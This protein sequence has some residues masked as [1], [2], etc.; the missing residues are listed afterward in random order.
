VFK[1]SLERHYLN[2]RMIRVIKRREH[3]VWKQNSQTKDLNNIKN[4]RIIAILG[5]IAINSLNLTN[6]N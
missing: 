2:D 6:S 5:M 3:G 4:V 1:D